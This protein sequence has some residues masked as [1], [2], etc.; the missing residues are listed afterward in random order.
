MTIALTFIKLL[1]RHLQYSLYGGSD[2]KYHLYHLYTANGKVEA[3]VFDTIE[4]AEAEAY[5]G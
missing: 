1:G 4:D 5:F 2:K 3:G